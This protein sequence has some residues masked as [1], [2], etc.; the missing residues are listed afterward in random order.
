MRRKR[1]RAGQEVVASRLL[2][3]RHR[4]RVLPLPLLS[5]VTPGQGTHP[6]S[7]PVSSGVSSCMRAPSL[8]GAQG[9]PG[10]GPGAAGCPAPVDALIL[11]SPLQ[12]DGPCACHVPW[13]HH[14][15]RDMGTEMKPP[16][17]EERGTER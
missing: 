14:R 7:L 13:K 16:T 15:P 12:H 2:W 17:D 9:E 5:C 10:A 4:V 1:S 11:I 8:W 6:C 3:L